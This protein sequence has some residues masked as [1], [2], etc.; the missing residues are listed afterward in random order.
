MS[1]TNKDNKYRRDFYKS[2]SLNKHRHEAEEES[3][4]MEKRSQRR[5]QKQELKEIEREYRN[6]Q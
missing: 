1:R 6:E 2:V 4:T 5:K 3:L